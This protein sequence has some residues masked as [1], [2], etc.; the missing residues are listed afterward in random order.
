MASQTLI[1]RVAG[2]CVVLVVLLFIPAC[3]GL[4]VSR[5]DRLKHD[6]SF[7]GDGVNAVAA[8][9]LRTRLN[10]SPY[11]SDP[12]Y[13]AKIEHAATVLDRYANYSPG[14]VN[15]T[16]AS[17]GLTSEVTFSTMRSGTVSPGAT[18]KYKLL[19]MTQV[20]SSFQPTDCVESSIPIGWYEIWSERGST[21]TSD[22]SS[23]II[24]NEN[25]SI[26]LQEKP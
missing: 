1:D 7:P 11:S 26:T 12:E 3:L 22:K 18:I 6:P 17:T 24:I 15:E 13:C 23:F 25:V 4:N 20:L 5:D 14:D 19:G 10:R 2:L 16:L 8:D 9:V 21:S